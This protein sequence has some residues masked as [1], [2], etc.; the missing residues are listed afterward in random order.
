MPRTHLRNLLARLR[1]VRSERSLR[2]FGR[3]L[4]NANLWHLNRY[5]VS[6][7]VS[8]GL[9]VAFVPVP[10]QMVLAA[11][12]AILIGC[13]LPIAVV[14]V[15]F[16][17]PITM[18]PLFFAA[19]KLGSWLLDMTPRRV[20]FEMS[21]EWLMTRLDDIWQPLLLGCFIMGFAAALAGHAAVRIIWRI[22]VRQSWHARRRRRAHRATGSTDRSPA[23]RRRAGAGRDPYAGPAPHRASPRPG[24]S[25]TPG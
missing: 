6:W 16:S 9:F 5:S 19:Y 17:N 20:Q 1:D 24:S 25:E 13:N 11:A 3:L 8:V 4:H 12:A 14:M 7:A 21:F 18:P 2:L 22:H 15:W 10:F 23:A